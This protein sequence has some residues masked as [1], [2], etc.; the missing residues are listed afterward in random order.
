MTKNKYGLIF[1]QIKKF[2]I[3]QNKQR[4]RGLNNYNILTSVLKTSD[5]VRLHSRMIFSFLNPNGEHYQSNLFL[6]I[7]LKT[8]KIKNFNID[9]EQCLVYKEYRNIDL[10]ITDGVKH[11]I[12]ENKIYAG[13]QK[14]QISRYIETIQEEN[15]LN[16]D[17]ILVIYLTL[18]REKPSQY[19]LD[20]FEIEHGF[21]KNEGKNIALFKS[22][23]YKNEILGWLKRCQY[24]VQNITNLN[25]AFR[26]Y[27]DVVKMINHN[28]KDKIMSLS[29]YILEENQEIYE[30][31]SQLQN[32]FSKARKKIVDDFFEEIKNEL[33]D[34]L[35]DKW[36]VEIKFEKNRDF[37]VAYHFPFRI[38]KKSWIKNK[39][40]LIFGFEFR[41]RDYYNGWFGIVR[42]KETINIKDIL[43]QF[44]S[45]IDSINYSL[46]TNSWWLHYVYTPTQKGDFAKYIHYENGKDE[47]KKKVL[48]LIYIFEDKNSLMTNINSY[49]NKKEK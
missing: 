16:E 35:G 6:D 1:E 49:L 37:S 9:I 26:Q 43:K 38:Y 48:E 27:I 11:I 20:K 45:E 31:A 7:F 18:N 34:E 33:E 2:K 44:Q 24:E 3:E 13:D 15:Y 22:I 14:S 4:Q 17:D 47:F 36:I 8:L 25:E 41:E 39:H 30:L 21:I 23:H 42:Q 12:I 32:E 46:K 28:Y 29:D 10:Y 19:S 5:E 40:N